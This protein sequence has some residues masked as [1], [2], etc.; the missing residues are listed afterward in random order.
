MTEIFGLETGLDFS[1][2]NLSGFTVYLMW[3]FGFLI[4]GIIAIVIIWYF[5]KRKLFKYNIVIFENVTGQ[6]FVVSKKDKARTLRLAKDGTEIFYLQKE[7]LCLSAY[8]QKMGR[9]QYW[10]VIG[11][12]GGWYNFVL[13]DFD[14]KTG[15][16]D[17]DLIDRDLRPAMVN[18]LNQSNE[19]YGAKQSFM[20][21]W[22]NQ[23]FAILYW[24]IIIAGMS[25]L[26]SQMG[27]VVTQLVSALDAQGE[28]IKILNQILGR[29]DTMYSG[30][31]GIKS[32]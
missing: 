5:N 25:Y 3:I 17:I 28:T 11:Q 19:E 6:G 1:V 31:M 23:I 13:G 22:G 24:I 16:L 14:A 7:K 2:G 21:K 12:D 26:I 4:L 10:F 20:D 15:I 29:L 18:M 9:N 32:A 30:G 8:G 27:E